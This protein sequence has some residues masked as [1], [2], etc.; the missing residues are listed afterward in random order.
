VVEIVSHRPVVEFETP[1][2]RAVRFE[3]AASVRRPTPYH[4][5]DA[6]NVLYLPDRPE[7]AEIDDP[8]FL[9]M[10]AGMGLF[11]GGLLLAVAVVGRPRR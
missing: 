9:W 11:F 3:S 6:V 4:P 7:K 8:R 2:G 10:P 1:A 5:G